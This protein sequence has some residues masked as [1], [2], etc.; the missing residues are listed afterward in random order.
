MKKSAKFLLAIVL[1]MAMAIG[2]IACKPVVVTSDFVVKSDGSGSRSFSVAVNS[3]ETVGYGS[4]YDYFKKHGDDLK[5][6]I[7]DF[8]NY[9]WLT[10]TVTSKTDTTG[11]GDEA[12]TIIT[13]TM[14]ISFTFANFNEYV[15]RIESLIEV[16]GKVIEND[17]KSYVAPSL[18]TEQDEDDK[19][20]YHLV[21]SKEVTKAVYNTMVDGFLA[22]DSVFD[23]TGGGKNQGD[24]SYADFGDGYTKPMDAAA[25]KAN[26]SSTYSVTVALCD[27]L[28][29]EEGTNVRTVDLSTSDIDLRSYIDGSGI[30]FVRPERQLVIYYDFD[31]A[32]TNDTTASGGKAYD[33][34]VGEGSSTSTAS[35]AE[36]IS[37][38]GYK[39]DGTSYLASKTGVSAAE[40]TISFYY[41][42]DAWTE[43]DTG[44]N[45]VF[46]PAGL[47]AL[48]G[49]QID[50]EF[51]DDPD[52]E[53]EAWFFMGKTNSANDFM[54]QDKLYSETVFNNRLDEWHHYV[55]VW[56]NVY[57]M[58]GVI[59]DAYVTMYVDGVQINKMGQ[60]N[61]SGLTKKLGEGS[62]FNVGGYYETELV[63]R[64]LTGTLDEVKIW[65]G[66]MT[67]DEVAELYAENTVSSAYDVD[68]DSNQFENMPLTPTTDDGGND[69]DKDE[70]KGG[71]CSGAI[72]LG[73]AGSIGIAAIGV[74]LVAVF[75]KKERE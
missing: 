52:D 59:E 69:G 13:E 35:Y 48:G 55:I 4:V 43:T 75:R 17:Y 15:S 63:K 36:G 74:A 41:K 66:L 19:D 73:A 54:I 68:D 67:A 20:Y 50:V 58:T 37:G 45:M 24:D 56:E 16:G 11:T 71:G 32:L 31:D 38:K 72:G 26:L 28:A 18:T 64:G 12:V 25:L 2:L 33:L 53:R 10:V 27:N 7:E 23:V 51:I 22:D 30:I 6:W 46:V 21:E 3:G 34:T 1:C 42:A 47:D 40:M 39:F 62:G 65:N 60:Y 29:A 14:T 44:A 49:G 8:Y 5:T 61:G 9:D 70:N 57:S